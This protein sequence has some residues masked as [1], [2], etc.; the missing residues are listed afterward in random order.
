M[1]GVR[2]GFVLAEQSAREV[3]QGWRS[4][5]AIISPW[6]YVLIALSIIYGWRYPAGAEFRLIDMAWQI[7]LMGVTL[8]LAWNWSN[9]L[10]AKPER[11][12]FS[13]GWEGGWVEYAGSLALAIFIIPIVILIIVSIG[14]SIP[15]T[16]LS[17][18]L[19]YSELSSGMMALGVLIVFA[20]VLYYEA[21]ILPISP[22]LIAHLP[23]P[24]PTVWKATEAYKTTLFTALAVLFV[25]FS[26]FLLLLG[27]F[28]LMLKNL[29]VLYAEI[30]LWPVSLV[31]TIF[32]YG[33]YFLLAHK[34]YAL[35]QK[36]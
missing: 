2:A 29:G 28:M 17:M 36:G 3:L 25:G 20:F 1:Q 8:L 32:F 35:V 19:G 23:M 9:A 22:A 34:A 27:Q 6:N 18:L 16:L 5:W 31:F 10:A 33:A 15:I 26:L 11:L 30:L 12:D 13:R 24:L 4:Y 7:L 14:V 21:R